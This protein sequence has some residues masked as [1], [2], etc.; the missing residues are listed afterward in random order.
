MLKSMSNRDVEQSD[1]DQ[2]K[3][4][5]RLQCIKADDKMK[6]AGDD[7][8]EYDS[9][10]NDTTA[11]EKNQTMNSWA[12]N[13]LLVICVVMYA[14]QFYINYKNN[15]QLKED[16]E[17]A[18][19][20]EDSQRSN[21]LDTDMYRRLAAKV[22]QQRVLSDGEWDELDAEINTI[23]VSFRKQLYD[24]YKMSEQEYRICMLIRLGMSNTE[25]S[26]LIG[27]GKSTASVARKRLYKKFFGK[28]GQATDFDTF[29]NSL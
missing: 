23:V 28:D 17:K 22:K 12:M 13:V 7:T 3:V 20:E 19:S 5:Y 2:Q 29:I 15:K 26:I 8:G 16:E 21:L 1:G 27:R 18:H 25:I 14:F 4:Y 9:K 6:I 10:I 24:I 11:K